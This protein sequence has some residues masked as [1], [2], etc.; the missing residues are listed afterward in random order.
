MRG[1]LAALF[2]LLPALAASA[3]PPAR[4]LD[5]VVEIGDAAAP[6]AGFFIDSNGGIATSARAVGD[7]ATVA[8]RARGREEQTGVVVARDAKRDLAFVRVTGLS[9]A[10]LPLG[11]AG[12]GGDEILAL[13]PGASQVG[14]IESLRAIDEVDFVELSGLGAAP[15]GG[16]VVFE[17]TG[18]AIGVRV[19]RTSDEA[20]PGAVLA[21][22]VP[23]FDEAFGCVLRLRGRCDATGPPA[24]DEVAR[25]QQAARPKERAEPEPVPERERRSAA[26]RAA[27]DPYVHIA[28]TRV[29]LKRPPGMVKSREFSGFQSPDGNL[30]ILVTELHQPLAEASRGYTEEELAKAGIKLLG[31]ADV[32]IAERPGFI[33]Y[34]AKG[35][36]ANWLAAFGEGDQTV[37]LAASA[38]L[39]QAK[40]V[41]D[42]M[43]ET[44]VS[45]RWDVASK[46]DPFDGLDWEL[47]GSLRL[48][49]AQRMLGDL[50]FTRD[51]AMPGEAWDEP[52]LVIGKRA[53]RI[54]PNA[55]A[56]ACRRAI[57]STSGVRDVG[58]V[59]IAE[60]SREGLPGCEM[61]ATATDEKS[62]KG[63][64]LYQVMLFDGS[65]SY[66]FR[67][68]VG[69]NKQYRYL[70]ELLD[71]CKSF[72]RRG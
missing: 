31:R 47:A 32:Q 20:K 66:W 62:G 3:E 48:K 61:A 58:N 37:V 30:R 41:S 2:A 40:E 59:E 10:H 18:E 60:T 24:E 72:R 38:P 51:G 1:S 23:E 50:T 15:D 6:A 52:V 9:L 64:I 34:S 55:R 57:G 46:G 27:A 49:L 42:L 36:L 13:A 12:R 67:G 29:S 11:S 4:W 43:H 16:P 22:A 28:G 70:P 14:R 5:A 56:D 7:A 33:A 65:G 39:A 44:L 45:A 71:V 19:T 35:N 68:R 25:I 26:E 69:V 53:G 63:V 17:P 8:V 54:E 21:V